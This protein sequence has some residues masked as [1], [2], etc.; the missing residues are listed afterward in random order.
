MNKETD[1]DYHY[2]KE[3]EFMK[4]FIKNEERLKEHCD[5]IARNGESVDTS[6]VDVELISKKLKE[7]YYL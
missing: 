4:K 5:W 6:L 1:Y 2:K 7:N 3:Y